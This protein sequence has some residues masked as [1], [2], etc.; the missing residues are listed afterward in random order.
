M[1]YTKGKGI[2]D[3]YQIKVARVAPKHEFFDEADENDLRLAFEIEYVTHL[4]EDYKPIKLN[5]LHTFTDT[6]LRNLIG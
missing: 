5:I 1:P 6:K 3:L 2:R 4:Y